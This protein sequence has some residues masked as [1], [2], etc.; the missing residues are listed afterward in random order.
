MLILLVLVV[1]IFLGGHPDRLPGFARDAL[2][3]DDNSKLVDEAL[4]VLQDDYYRPIDRSQLVNRGLQGAVASLGDRFSHYFDPKSY[5]DFSQ[6][7][8]GQFAGVGIVVSRDSLGLRVRRVLPGTPAAKAGLRARDVVTTVDGRSLKGKKSTESSALIRGKAGTL[9][10]LTIRHGGRSRSVRIRRATMSER[11][12]ASRLITR[13]KTKLAYAALAQF[14]SGA[15]AKLYD[16]ISKQLRK[17]AKGVI[18]DLRGNPGG[19]LDEGVLVGSIFLPKGTT[20]VSTAGRSRARHV[21]PAEGG[22][23]DPKIP[24][25][26]IVDRNTAS[27]AEIVSGALQDRKRAKLIGTNSFGKGVFQEVRQLS[28]G[29][30]LDITV[31]EYFLPS[32]RNLGGGGVKEG[33][34]LAPDVRVAEDAK[35]PG[36]EQLAAAERVLAGEIR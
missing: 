35:H 33:K 22:S 4:G 17:G 10:T 2:V 5:A 15:H 29:G 27:A 24:V 19:L 8:S 26:V 20:V 16:G 11:V 31:G 1:G 25:V 18:L 34:G 32:G 28:N 13:G 7:T 12:V 14:T 23:I 9:V 3:Q 30:A 36:D 6:Q 21:Y